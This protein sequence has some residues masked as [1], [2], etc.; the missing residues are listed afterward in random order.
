M[1][2]VKQARGAR[3]TRIDGLLWRSRKRSRARTRNR[4]RAPTRPRL[5]KIGVRL[6]RFFTFRSDLGIAADEVLAGPLVRAVTPDSY[7]QAAGV[8]PGDIIV[9]VGDTPVFTRTD[10]WFFV[11]EHNVGE[12]VE[13]AYVRD[14]EIRAGK[15]ALTAPM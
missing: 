6:D 1:K 5:D 8:E 12:E 3:S 7:A 15:A 4:G 2:R 13:I 10:L 11:R 9:K 14:G